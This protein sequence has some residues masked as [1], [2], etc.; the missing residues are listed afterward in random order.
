MT[1]SSSCTLERA[2]KTLVQQLLNQPQP[3]LHL[4]ALYKSGKLCPRK[5]I[6]VVEFLAEVCEDLRMHV[7]TA[8]L[9]VAIFDRFSARVAGFPREPLLFAAAAIALASKFLEPTSPSFY[10]LGELVGRSTQQIQ[11]AELHVINAIGW[12]LHVA[13][14]HAVA[15]NIF[16]L[17]RASAAC[18]LRTEAL[19]NLSYYEHRL[20]EHSAM[21]V[22]CA[23]LM[24]SWVQLSDLDSEANYAQLLCSV[25][26]VGADEL[27]RCRE[28]LRAAVT[29]LHASSAPQP[30]KPGRESP[31]SIMKPFEA[32]AECAEPPLKRHAPLGVGI[33]YFAPLRASSPAD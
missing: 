7:S 5:R 31:N 16:I 19:I 20:L 8:G 4:A 17:V 11:D 3:N 22:A 12:D 33:N 21:A 2:H 23:A 30:S 26:G 29:D 25:A 32:E 10:D 28:T 13:T 9:A 14:P 24:L 1:P 15:D 27:W 18:R 6:L